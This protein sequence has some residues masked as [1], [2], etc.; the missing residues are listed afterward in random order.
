MPTIDELV[1][2]IFN[3]PLTYIAIG[4]LLIFF[5]IKEVNR[6]KLRPEQKP[7]FGVRYRAKRVADHLK[8]REK[9][10]SWSPETKALLFNGIRPIGKILKIEEIPQIVK[11][12][13]TN[14][15]KKKGTQ[16]YIWIIRYRRLGFM[17]WLISQ[18]GMGRQTLLVDKDSIKSTFNDFRKYI[19]Y[20]IDKDAFFRERGGMLILSRD[21]ERVFIDEI[22]SDKDYENAKGFVPDF[23][24]RLSN[25]HPSHA[26]HTDTLEVEQQLEEKSKRSFMDRFRKG[27]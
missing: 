13:K 16:L 3:H 7:D 2:L 20:V 10:L 19:Q 21:P 6:G 15:S 14:P 9:A 12:S 17:N 25:L 27:G 23:P 1:V 24:R 26:I 18:M 11:A 5:I 8:K 22:N 4:G